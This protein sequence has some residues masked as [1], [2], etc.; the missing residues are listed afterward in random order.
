MSSVIPFSTC[1]I[2]AVFRESNLHFAAEYIANQFSSTVLA[3]MYFT[4]PVEGLTQTAENWT[5]FVGKLCDAHG[6]WFGTEWCQSGITGSSDWLNQEF[7][8]LLLIF[9]W[10][11]N[12]VVRICP[13][14]SRNTTPDWS[15]GLGNWIPRPWLWEYTK[16]L[17][18]AF[19]FFK[20]GL[21]NMQ[22]GM[23]EK[24]AIVR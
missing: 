16:L 13:L 23:D 12:I 19:T 8:V 22:F 5:I 9:T 18:P 15:I 7:E 20:E 10:F 4:Y 11:P 2:H 3:S 1:I 21:G 24:F 14:F 17:V 6:I